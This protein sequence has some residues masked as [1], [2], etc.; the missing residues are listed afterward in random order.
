MFSNYFKIAFRNIRRQKLYTIIN[1][2]GLAIGMACSLLILLFVYEELTVDNFHEN[3]DRIYRVY[4][5]LVESEN[6]LWTALTPMPLANDLVNEPEVSYAACMAL[7][8]RIAIRYRFF[9]DTA[10][11]EI[12]TSPSFFNIFSFTFIQGNRSKALLDPNSM[13][14]TDKL[15]KTIFKQENPIGKTLHVKNIGN[16]TVTGIIKEQRNTHIRLGVILPFNLYQED[17]RYEP[18]QR[19]NYFTYIRLQKNA[20]PETLG[21]K[22]VEYQKKIYGLGARGQYLLQP[23]TDIWL[24]SNLAYDFLTAPYGI[25][26]IYTIMTLAAI[27][28]ITACMNY[29][30]LATAQSE[31][32][33]EE[34]GLRKV[35]GADRRQIVL[36]FLG[37]AILLCC[38]ALIVSIIL[39]EI[40]L[41]GFNDLVEIKEISLF[42]S[43][44]LGIITVFILVAAFTGIISGSYPAFFVSAFQPAAIIRRQ[45]ITGKKGTVLRKF[46]LITQFA[47][48]IILVISTLTFNGQLKYMLSKDLGYHPE[49]LLYVPMSVKVRQVYESIK[50]NLLQHTGISHV[51]ASLNLPTWRGPSSQLEQWEGNTAGKTIRMY[52][53]SVD[54]DFIDTF[55][56]QIIRGTDFS[57][58]SAPDAP[59]GLIVNEEAVRQMELE[60]P[61]GKRLTMWNHDGPIIGVVKNF[62]FNNVKNKVEPL[63]LKLAP[64]EARVCIIRIL[65][66]NVPDVLSFI[67]DNFRRV[68]ADFAIKP[69]FLSDS[70]NRMYTLEQKMSQLFGYSTFLA[71]L[72]SCLGLFGLSAYTIEKRTKELA[73]RKACGATITRIVKMLSVEF[74][75]LVFIANLIAWPLAYFS[76]NNWLQDYAY[77]MTLKATPF[78]IATALAFIVAL[79]TVGFQ[80]MKAARKNPVDA[81][82]YE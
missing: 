40:F 3:V 46:L 42:E 72:I 8:D 34:V 9:N 44:N 31:G 59:S 22:L 45:M 81:L 70:L 58:T 73:I 61:I 68:D 14:L 80:A 41:P 78:L 62:H 51:T 50:E 65:P 16:L 7:G 52:H 6:E 1:V 57:K 67:E 15:A 39:T 66:E 55:Q 47:I 17:P 82:R 32:R 56:M 69:E 33:I 36:Q 12:Y 4:S 76:V 75:K 11:T 54:H 38:M 43:K 19:Y 29:M 49:N 13:V 24:H 2:T 18:W 53:G 48:A 60:E 5:G 35:M 63:V 37:E 20:E 23:V 28:L 21:R 64:E 10:T 30:N 71:I 79:L 25:N 26:V 74:L 77:H 27:I